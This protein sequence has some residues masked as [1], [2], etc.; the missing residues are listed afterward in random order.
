MVSW[1]LRGG[2]DAALVF[3]GLFA[4]GAI[5]VGVR[6]K[7]VGSFTATRDISLIGARTN[8]IIPQSIGIMREI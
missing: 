8:L 3:W 6:V 1:V 7:V 2:R 4:S 5:G